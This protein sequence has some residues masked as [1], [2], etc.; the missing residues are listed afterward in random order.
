VAAKPTTALFVR[1]PQSQARVLDRLAFES[2]R[3]KQAVVSELLARSIEQPAQRRVVI[4]PASAGEDL[5]GRYAFWP[6]EDSP[7]AAGEVLTLEEAAA[8]LRVQPGDVEDLAGR[9]GLPGRRIG[10]HWRFSRAAVLAW[11][12]DGAVPDP[13]DG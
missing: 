7:A 8:L 11:L 9:G 2:G 13:A 6:D 1:I 4:E 10:A 3:P 12:G 5:R